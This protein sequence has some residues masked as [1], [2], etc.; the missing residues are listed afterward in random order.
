MTMTSSQL[1]IISTTMLPQRRNL[2]LKLM[3]SVLV[4]ASL[5][6]NFFIL[7]NVSPVS[8]IISITSND[9]SGI[10][11]QNR[12]QLGASFVDQTA[13]A[14]T[15]DRPQVSSGRA[16]R[17]LDLD[18]L[19]GDLSKSSEIKQAS[20]TGNRQ[21]RFLSGDAIT[22]TDT[23]AKDSVEGRSRKNGAKKMAI[24][25][26]IPIVSLD[27]SNKSG[28]HVGLDSLTGA[29]DND[30]DDSATGDSTTGEQL[31]QQ[32]YAKQ[33]IAANFG[34]TN[35]G[36][37]SFAPQA[38][39]QQSNEQQQLY[40]QDARGR[41]LLNTGGLLSGHSRRLISSL[42]AP[43]GHHNNP[44]LQQPVQVPYPLSGPMNVPMASTHGHTLV[45]APVNDCI[46]VPFFQC[47]NGYLGESQL[48][49]SQLQ[50]I[51]QMQQSQ[52][53]Q[54]PRS[55]PAPV[56]VNHLQTPSYDLYGNLQQQQ[57]AKQQPASN[58]IS[59]PADPQ[60]VNDIYE[61]LR[62]NIEI[63]NLDQQLQYVG[64]NSTPQQMMSGANY[65]LLDERSK[66]S[67][68]KD[69]ANA[70][71][72][73][74]SD[75]EER[76]LLNPTSSWLASRRQGVMQ[77]QP[78]Q[79]CG[80][81]R[82]CCRIPPTLM[83]SKPH[84]MQRPMMQAARL[85][86]SPSHLHQQ[87]GAQVMR[88]QSQ[89]HHSAPQYQMLQPSIG[90]QQQPGQGY[91]EAVQ[92]QIMQ[93]DQYHP[94]VSAGISG[95]PVSSD[96][97]SSS[98][99]GYQSQP[100]AVS[101]HPARPIAGAPGN[102]A[103]GFMSG[104]CGVRQAFGISGRVQNNQPA[105]GTEVTADFGEFPAHAAILKRI[106]P[107]D[108]LF[109]CSAV[110]VSNQWLATAAHCVRRSRPDELKIRLGEWDVNRDDEFY[111]F[112]ESNVREI[113]IHPEFQPTSLHN[114][115]ALLRVENTMDQQ[116]MPH[117]APACLATPNDP[118]TLPMTGNGQQQQQRCWV[119][120]WGKDA[121]GQSGTF[122]SVLKKVDLPLVSRQDCEMALR[123]HTKLGRYFR[124]HQANVCA[125]GE[126]GKDACE[127]DG[128]AG[129]YCLDPETGLSK[130]VGLVS[131]GIGCGQ[132]GVPGVYTSMGAFYQW[133]ESVVA[134][135]GEE[136]IYMDRNANGISDNNFK[137][138][139]TER[140]N[141]R[142][143]NRTTTESADQ[144]QARS[145]YATIDV[146]NVATSTTT[147]TTGAPSNST[148]S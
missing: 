129:L 112:V 127:G 12:S 2:K 21:S 98:S 124:L 131:W 106:S 141:D 133:I 56:P 109:V 84:A 10:A 35:I 14:T 143:G 146:N 96:Y 57:L 54:V 122:Q 22:S 135:S 119:A 107:G 125:G 36:H 139:I 102:T 72:L 67:S 30:E 60:L 50:H 49:R 81:M 142:T 26:F 115:I 120:G 8:G 34:Q 3:I 25:G 70:T 19:S 75:V 68:S 136:G 27:D 90:Q 41:K 6:V 61:Q 103:G 48:S 65:P 11:P 9:L 88:P 59:Q 42:V 97:M 28:K 38:S 111:P 89:Q 37:A 86:L 15:A 1:P 23:A 4:S 144:T 100:L 16:G 108:S 74:V 63:G 29:E 53:N 91:L 39:Q 137:G 105:L 40:D 7:L 69:N 121:F 140:T 51:N 20:T 126:R 117:I 24:K 113:I 85:D 116:Q 58:P 32:Q 123:F 18:K 44:H 79:R 45:D 92:N 94:L 87:T 128:G 64:A 33:Q 132:T 13:P 77:Q 134:A 83:V 17:M 52:S 66:G 145:M 118:I 62:K 104:R 148:A 130:A 93:H 5:F 80:I 71:V 99:N 73:P 31:M 55:L 110:L 114:D 147:T 101:A 43:N 82:T 78:A 138:L 47:K 95:A 76:S 46:C